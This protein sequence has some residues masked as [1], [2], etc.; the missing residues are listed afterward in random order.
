MPDPLVVGRAA[1][2]LLG[3][4][5]GDA[6]GWPS[7]YHRSHR[8]PFWTR[9]IRRELDAESEATFIIRP[10]V[11]FSL[12]QPP[13]LLALGPTDDAEWV[14]FTAR[15]LVANRGEL[16]EDALT[17]AWL[18]LAESG[19]PIKG[20]VSVQAALA[21]LRKGLR[22]PVTGH[23][24]PHYFDDGA[25][26][27]AVACGIA[28]AGRPDEAARLAEQEATVTNAL[29][30]VWGAR[31]IAAAVAA[32][33]GGA[34]VSTAVD[35]AL[36]QLPKD[37]WIGRTTAKALA[38]AEPGADP[39]A[40]LP[41][42]SDTVVDRVYSYGTGAPETVALTLAIVRLTA[43]DLARAGL[44]AA[45]IVRTADSLPALVGALCG[46]LTG[47]EAVPSTWQ[48]RCRVLQ[49]I[50]LPDLAGEDLLVL[51]QRLA[52]CADFQ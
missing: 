46:A 2:A 31:A 20:G 29:D 3:L 38:L 13:S 17:Q 9:R 34:G 5:V 10:P 41:V 27:R 50:C 51:A 48:E 42:L 22:P 11:P 18:T 4:A 36:A 25:C 37:S 40:V 52:A 33:C 28:R 7:L 8:L 45:A 21:N 1:G 43:G 44:L 12:N 32:S 23:D 39:F 15:L 14:A 30:G 19:L 24:N 35:V 26:V 6:L 47:L 16:P 49:G